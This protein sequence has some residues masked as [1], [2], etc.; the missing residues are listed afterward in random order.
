MKKKKRKNTIRYSRL[1]ILSSLLL[2]CL[3]IGRTIEL[4]L[5]TE[6]DGVNLKKLA[7]SRTTRTD[8]EE[9]KRGSI[10]SSNGDILAQNVSS[11]KLIAYLDSK[12]TTNE[13]RP[14]HVVNKEETAEK[15]SP[16]LGMEKDEILTFLNKEGVYQTEFGVK[17]KD[18][19]EIA[20]KQIEDLNLPGL[21]FIESFRRYYPK[22]NF[23]SYTIGYTKNNDQDKTIQG[24]MGIEKQY[25]EIL[26]GEDGKTTY[27]KD[28][29]G[30]KIADTP[31]IKKRCYSRKKYLFNN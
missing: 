25:N 15:L 9:A 23:A 11:Y 1:I 24:E 8:I 28:L 30:Y 31:V 18:L 2:F 17:G 27:Q 13:K 29:K 6:I 4:G 3:M 7:S 5:S 10:Y 16:I 26:K 21:D 12:R 22:G 19:N 14:Q 20:K